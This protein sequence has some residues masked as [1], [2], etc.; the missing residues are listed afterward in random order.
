MSKY[1]LLSA[2]KVCSKGKPLFRIR[3]EKDLPSQ[4]VKKGDLGGLVHDIQNLPQSGES[5]ISYR[6]Q[7]LDKASVTG[8][9]RVGGNAIIK[10][11]SEIAGH[12]RVSGS[13]VLE[14][15]YINGFDIE[16][17]ERAVLKNVAFLGNNV[18]IHGYAHM[19]NVK[20]GSQL[21]EF[22]MS[23]RSVITSSGDMLELDCSHGVIKENAHVENVMA[24]KGVNIMIAGDA[25]VENGVTIDGKD[26]SISD[27]SHVEGRL[28][29]SDNFSISDVASLKRGLV[30]A[31]PFKNISITGDTALSTNAFEPPYDPFG[32]M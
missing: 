21:G 20:K 29:I 3:A 25:V 17:R 27:C 12:A 23:G 32:G 26:I 16:I 5:W 8:N 7:V 10:G 11:D 6:A 13:A 14:D 18:L 22:E 24:I 19:E 1:V 31:L 2:E 30:N 9:A 4:N 15:V 28:V